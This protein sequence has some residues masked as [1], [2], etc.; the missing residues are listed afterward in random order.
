MVEGTEVTFHKVWGWGGYMGQILRG[1]ELGKEVRIVP[2]K[3]V[4]L[5][6]KH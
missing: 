4:V 5:A 1:K 3:M 2:G 6:A